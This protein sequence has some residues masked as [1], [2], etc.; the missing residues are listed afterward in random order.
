MYITTF[1][2]T[3]QAT[4]PQTLPWIRSFMDAERIPIC[5]VWTPTRREC[6]LCPATDLTFRFL[7]RPTIFRV[8]SAL[9]CLGCGAVETVEMGEEGHVRRRGSDWINGTGPVRSFRQAIG[10]RRAYSMRC[11]WGGDAPDA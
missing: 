8:D 5:E 10:E 3:E 7:L 6:W 4:Q 9:L 11:L 2:L 1:L